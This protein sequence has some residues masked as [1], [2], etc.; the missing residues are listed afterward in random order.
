M[1]QQACRRTREE[2]DRICIE[3]RTNAAR[4][5]AGSA[6]P[7]PYG[8]PTDG[9]GGHGNGT[10]G[11]GTGVQWKSFGL[12]SGAPQVAPPTLNISSVLTE[13]T[14]SIIIGR[15]QAHFWVCGVFEV[16]DG[17]ITLWRDYFDVWDM[18]KGTVR[19]LIEALLPS[20]RAMTSTPA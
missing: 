7:H 18:L 5:M 6:D 20:P 8:H 12:P 9:Y 14:D 15:F 19:G 1:Q 3:E 2:I 11:Y 10:L 16:I 4:R 17:K 13:R